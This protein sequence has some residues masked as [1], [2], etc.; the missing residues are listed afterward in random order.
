V[1]SLD[2]CERLRLHAA[3]AALCVSNC[4]EVALFACVNRRP[5]LTGENHRLSFAPYNTCYPSL[6]TDLAAARVRADCS[7][8]HW[9]RPLVFAAPNAPLPAATASLL[10]PDRFLPFTVPF[11]TAAAAAAAA[12]AAGAGAAAGAAAGA[13]WEQAAA[14]EAG[15]GAGDAAAPSGSNPVE[16]PPEYAQVCVCG[17]DPGAPP[18]AACARAHARARARARGRDAPPRHDP[19]RGEAL[20]HT[21]AQHRRPLGCARLH[22]CRR[23]WRPSSG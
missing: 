3:S 8:N 20:A 12:G 15:G 6:V 13:H 16:M 18:A 22:S 23:C 19:S 4:I 14:A 7:S 5:L 2:H 21:R 1:L 10:P 17:P 11:E 9:A